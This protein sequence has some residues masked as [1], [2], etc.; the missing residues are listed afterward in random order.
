MFKNQSNEEGFKKIETIIGPSVKVQGDFNSQG[1]IIV[2]GIVE[3]NLKTKGNL[4]IGAQAK[5]TADVEAKEAKISGKIN[6]NV[7]IKGY[8]ELSATAKI[9]GDIETESLSVERGAI[10]NGKCAMATEEKGKSHETE[11]QE[12]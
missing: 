5:I 7:K 3:G 1:N 4:R 9:T 12:S 8:L 2:E 6:G 10:I 11:K